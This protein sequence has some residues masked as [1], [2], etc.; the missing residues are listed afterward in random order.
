MSA[1]PNMEGRFGLQGRLRSSYAILPK[2]LYRGCLFGYLP[3]NDLLTSVD[4]SHD[5]HGVL[6]DQLKIGC[7]AL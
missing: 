3:I 2:L 1:T 4:I 7:H 6:A 5:D